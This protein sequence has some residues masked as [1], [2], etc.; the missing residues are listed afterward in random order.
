LFA[1]VDL[2]EDEWGVVSATDPGVRINGPWRVFEI[3]SG[4]LG[5]GG[6]NGECV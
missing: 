6:A 3:S 5:D 2:V 4:D 1:S